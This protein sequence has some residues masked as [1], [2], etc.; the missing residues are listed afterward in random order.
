MA[1]TATLVI[2]FG[3]VI[4]VTAIVCFTVHRIITL[5]ISNK[6]GKK[7][8]NGD[9]TQVIQEI[10]QGLIKMEERIESLETIL[11]DR[12]TKPDRDRADAEFFRE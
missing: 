1:A 5:A 4:I 3:F 12:R 6:G 10:Y 2:I 11:T 9:E 8:M 7:G